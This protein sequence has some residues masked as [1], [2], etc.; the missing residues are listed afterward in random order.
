MSQD[1]VLPTTDST[2]GNASAKAIVFMVVF[3][4]LL[5]FGIVLP[6][7]PL[8]AD[9]YVKQYLGEDSAQ[10]IEGL[11]L[12]LL[13]SSFSLMQFLFAPV[14][15]RISDRIGR[16]PVL[17]VGLAGSVLFYA[18]FG[19]AAGLPESQALTALGLLF[20]ARIGAGLSG[21]TIST[22]QAVIA[23]T[24]PK[25]KRKMGMALI[26]AA[27]GI[28]FTFGPL[29]G[30]AALKF[31]PG[32]AGSV[33][34]V[35]SGLSAIALLLGMA[36]LRETRQPTSPPARRNWFD[37]KGF[38]EVVSS[39]A[40]GPV[41]LVSFLATM[42]F[43]G[44]ESTLALMNDRILQLGKDSNFL[45]F[46]Y[47]GLVL[48]LANGAY[49][50]F[51]KRM[52]EETAMAIGIVIMGLGVTSLAGINFLHD[53]D[54]KSGLI[55]PGLLASLSFAVIGF[56]LLTPSAQGLISRRADPDRQGEILGVNQSCLSM[57]RIL[58]PIF[59]LSLYKASPMLPFLL[60]GILVLLMLPLVGRIRKAGEQV[61]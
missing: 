23:D 18:L 21:A 29:I 35:A 52:S 47:V 24:T 2:K 49:R 43:G 33:G 13:M 40:L 6:L 15:G 32:Q 14:W 3:I 28:G 7:L 4:D 34:Y 27:F 53:S 57:A 38:T 11:V 55:L 8:F 51:A 59:G 37:T 20:L 50:G 16:R 22:A 42:G 31:F 45:V 5:G 48:T 39:P 30:F 10:W 61:S 46:A 26:G 25:E 12:G 60:G 9:R 56:A 58:G 41:I 54:P 1:Q 44:F 19:F 17:L 36:R